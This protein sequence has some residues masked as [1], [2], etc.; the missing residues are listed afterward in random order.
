MEQLYLLS[1]VFRHKHQPEQ[2]LQ[3]LNPAM[4]TNCFEAVLVSL[5]Q[6]GCEE[7]M[8]WVETL[9]EAFFVAQLIGGSISGENEKYLGKLLE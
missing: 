9:T 6:G 2:I 8:A 5:A 3:R 7:T 1:L 4:L